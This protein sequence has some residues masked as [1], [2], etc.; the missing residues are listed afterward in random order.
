MGSRL[1]RIAVGLAIGGVVLQFGGCLSGRTVRRVL[2][3]AAFS[4]A[5][6]FLW[7]NDAVLDLFQ[8]DFG[9]GVFYNDRFVDDP[10]RLEP[11]AG[12]L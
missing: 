9:T 7:D 12:A 4:A 2:T 5:Y 11:G 6:E 10:S 3:D 1:R 8:D